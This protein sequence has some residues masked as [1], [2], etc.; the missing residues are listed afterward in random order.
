MT[1]NK[2]FV[3]TF[4][5]TF[6]FGFVQVFNVIAK[7]IVNKF[8]AYFLGAAGMGV[9]GIFN[10][11]I[12]LLKT[13]GGLGISQSAVRDISEASGDE[14]QY[15]FIIS[16]VKKLLLY[17][18]IFGIVLS[19]SLSPLL[20]SWA[21]NTHDYTYSFLLLSLVV[22]INIYTE[23]QLSILKGSR[24]LKMLA[25]CSMMGVFIG[26]FG[27][28]P[29][30]YYFGMKGIVPSIVIGALVPFLFS[31]YFVSKLK[32]SNISGAIS[33]QEFVGNSKPIVKMGIALMYVTF[34]G[35]LSDLIL[36]FYVSNYG[37]L[38][39]VGCYQA[40]IVIISGYFGIVITAM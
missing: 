36:S 6:L 18:S 1:I 11:A 38:S 23:G 33:F 17:S 35:A 31:N 12:N 2:G 24:Q 16:L 14:V 7:L 27:A 5:T 40:G 10:N 29:C 20:S 13:G 19:A 25:K 32:Y 4:K 30:Y 34:L 28:I 22:G 21:F 9:I 39:D 3:N 8:I 26:S 15:S 37:G